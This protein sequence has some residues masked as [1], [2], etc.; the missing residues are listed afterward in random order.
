MILLF[1]AHVLVKAKMF[2]QHARKDGRKAD[3]QANK[4]AGRQA[5]SQTGTLI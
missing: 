2:T 4:Q 1:A 3:K 5:G